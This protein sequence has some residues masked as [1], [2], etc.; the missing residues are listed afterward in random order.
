MG[1][2]LNTLTKPK[3]YNFLTFWLTSHLRSA[4]SSLGALLRAPVTSLMTILVFAIAM[5]L[6]MAFMTLLKGLTPIKQ[7]L[8]QQPQLTFYLQ[9]GISEPQKTVLLDQL[10]KNNA[11]ANVDYISPAQGWAQL[12]AHAHLTPAMLKLMQNPLPPVM[13]VTLKH[14]A[15]NPQ[16]LQTLAAQFTHLPGV[17]SVQLNLHWL[18]RL[19]FIVTLLKRLAIGLALLLGLGLF[20]VVANTIRL[21][22]QN[23]LIEVKVLKLVG[24]TAAFI[25]RPLLYRGL[26]LSLFG[27][28]GAWVLVVVLTTWLSMPL[29]RLAASYSVSIYSQLYD[30]KMVLLSCVMAAFIG[31]GAAWFVS[32]R[33]FRRAE[34]ENT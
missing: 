10:Q 1:D 11:V 34:L 28:M 9:S 12:T 4:L 24:A 6:P 22:L 33:F 21:V 5:A 31:V 15:T 30:F 16:Q 3:R 25:R 27:A 2:S 13:V 23:S 20:F 8:L 26:W 14:A 19:Y 18:E 29:S 32:N 17:D 7:Q